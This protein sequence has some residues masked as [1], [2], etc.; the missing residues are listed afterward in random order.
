MAFLLCPH[1]AQRRGK[2]MPVDKWGS[3]N[4]PGCHPLKKKIQIKYLASTQHTCPFPAINW[5]NSNHLAATI[6]SMSPFMNFFLFFFWFYFTLRWKPGRVSLLITCESITFQSGRWLKAG[7]CLPMTK[8]NKVSASLGALQLSCSACGTEP[9]HCRVSG[10]L[11]VLRVRNIFLLALS[12]LKQ[13]SSALPSEC[14]SNGI[15]EHFF[16]LGGVASGQWRDYF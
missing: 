16:F 15:K 11:Y 14:Y 13:L 1:D 12:F 2:L 9:T 7:V 4:I 10:L 8:T 3:G 5:Q 6:F